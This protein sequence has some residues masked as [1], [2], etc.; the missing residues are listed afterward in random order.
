MQSEDVNELLIEGVRPKFHA[1][2]HSGQLNREA[3]SITFPLHAAI[4]HGV[5]NLFQ[6]SR[7]EVLRPGRV[8]LDSTG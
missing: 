5:D 1:V 2:A 7:P 3:H 8:C 6:A 4:E